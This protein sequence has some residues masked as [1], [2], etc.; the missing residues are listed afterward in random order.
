[1]DTLDGVLLPN[2]T[3]TFTASI[4]L[5]VIQTAPDWVTQIVLPTPL[6]KSEVKPV[7]LFV[8][9]QN[10][11]VEVE[12]G[13]SPQIVRPTLAS[14]VIVHS[15][16][17]PPQALVEMAGLPPLPG[18]AGTSFE[19]SVVGVSGVASCWSALSQLVKIHTDAKMAIKNNCFIV[20]EFFP[21]RHGREVFNFPALP[22]ESDFLKQTVHLINHR[23]RLWPLPH[24]CQG[25]PKVATLYKECRGANGAHGRLQGIPAATL[26]QG[27]IPPGP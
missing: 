14:V 9:P 20:I 22:P 3:S 12:S 21:G 10:E 5:F 16:W 7:P 18:S 19:I 26:S 17:P 1:M 27:G 23:L 11:Q 13:T 2:T 25:W 4:L 6:R 24:T 15:H 8:P